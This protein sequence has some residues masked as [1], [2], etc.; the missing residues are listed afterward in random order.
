VQTVDR[1][2]VVRRL[3][4]SDWLQFRE[5][6]LRALAESPAAFGSTLE[7]ASQLDQAGWRDRLAGRAQFVAMRGSA[8]LGTA[9]GIAAGPG[10]GAELISMWVDPQAR[11][12]GVGDQMVSAILA[13]AKSQAHRAIVLWV[14]EG[15]QPA[16]RLYLRHGFR[17]TGAEKA[18]TIQRPDRREFEMS[19][20]LEA[21]DHK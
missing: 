3:D 19:R 11:G 13:W 4:P 9:A 18:M 16:E 6:R 10:G 20:R 1:T 15:N 8:A 12:S 7:E 2:V 21:S 5:I 14:A 17:R